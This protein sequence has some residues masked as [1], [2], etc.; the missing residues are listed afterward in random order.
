MVAEPDRL[1]SGPD[2]CDRSRVLGPW[3]VGEPDP[4]V[5]VSPCPESHVEQSADAHSRHPHGHLTRS[6]LGCIYLSDYEYVRVSEVIERHRPH[7]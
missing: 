1:D 4:G 6:D 3:D 2:C 5:R 7:P